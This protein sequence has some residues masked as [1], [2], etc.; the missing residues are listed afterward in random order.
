MYPAGIGRDPRVGTG[1]PPRGPSWASSCLRHHTGPE[2][3][4]PST[5]TRITSSRAARKYL[6]IARPPRRKAPPTEGKYGQAPY[7]MKIL[8][9][10]RDSLRLPT[11]A[12]LGRFQGH[13]S[14]V[15]GPY[16]R[17][18]ETSKSSTPQHAD[19]GTKPHPLR[20]EIGAG[21]G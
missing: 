2:H 15:A 4:L 16:E 6:P 1:Q 7:A 20:L 13:A 17:T 9:G 10:P 14:H 11:W 5:D 3:Y 21:P 8:L 12:I 18:L 19:P